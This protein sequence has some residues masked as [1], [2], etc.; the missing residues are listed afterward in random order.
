MFNERSLGS[1]MYIK[2]R[3]CLSLLVGWLSECHT[4]LG[5]LESG[6]IPIVWSIVNT[7]VGYTVAAED[8]AR[9]VEENH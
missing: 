1:H 3:R 2:F 9:R 7:Y 4:L 6:Y 5:T 8:V